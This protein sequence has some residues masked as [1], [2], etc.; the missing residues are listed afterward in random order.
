MRSSEPIDPEPGRIYKLALTLVADGYFAA[1][2][3]AVGTTG[4]WPQRAQPR[5]SS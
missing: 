2:P 5:A 3:E 1:A 4:P